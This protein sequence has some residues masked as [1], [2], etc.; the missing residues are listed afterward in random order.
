MKHI[1]NSFKI[2]FSMYSKIPMPASEW[3]EQNMRYVMCFFP[4]IGVP[5]G[6]LTLCWRKAAE[7][8]GMAGSPFSVI[9]LLLIPIFISGGIHLDGLLDTADALHSYLE[10]EKRLEILKDPRAGA[11]AII[12]AIVYFLFY[13]GIYSYLESQAG[14]S[15]VKA[16]RVIACS[17]VVSRALSGYAVV[18]FPKAKNT[19]L[20]AAFSD[21]AQ[22]KA[23]KIT[24]ICYVAVMAVLMVACNIFYALAAL[25]AAGIV[26]CY[27]RKMSEEKFGG[28][29][30][31]LAGWFLQNCELFMAFAVLAVYVVS[32]AVKAI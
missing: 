22:K 21:N 8:L 7:W 20:A 32:M 27:Y 19:G 6:M 2:A 29:T 10:K 5:I 16:W 30:G 9:I 4:L 26:F 18:D 28:I 14:M 24:M 13:Y 17:F 11:F 1:W 15:A 23:V 25:A 12:Q 31:D 3:N